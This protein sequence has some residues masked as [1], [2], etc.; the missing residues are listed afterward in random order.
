MSQNSPTDIR[1]TKAQLIADLS[2]E[3]VDGMAAMVACQ[4]AIMCSVMLRD[5]HLRDQCGIGVVM[6]SFGFQIECPSLHVR[7]KDE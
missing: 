5:I 1:G 4:I 2:Q 7:R 6:S 3:V